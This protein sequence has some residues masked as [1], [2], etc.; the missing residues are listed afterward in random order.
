MTVPPSFNWNAWIDVMPGS[1]PTLY[2]TGEVQTGAANLV[3]VLTEAV[4]Q[5][6]NPA[7]LLLDL[8]IV[9]QGVGIQLVAFRPA[10]FEKAAKQGQYSH[11]EI[12]F[13]GELVAYERVQTIH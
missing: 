7:I 4:P 9:Q 5:G 1:K 11:V 8:T 6:I 13:G 2:V 10:R 12:R 3:P